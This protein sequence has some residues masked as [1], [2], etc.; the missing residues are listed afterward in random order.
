[1]LRELII[2]ICSL[3]RGPWGHWLHR[4]I[5]SMVSVIGSKYAEGIFEDDT[6][7]IALAFSL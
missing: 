4:G 6:L 3:K 2:I 5:E 1:L 7:S